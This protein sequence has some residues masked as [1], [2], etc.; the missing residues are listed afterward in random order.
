MPLLL[1]YTSFAKESATSSLCQRV[2]A[3]DHVVAV[4]MSI[5]KYKVPAQQAQPS[6]LLYSI[7]PASA[8]PNA[9]IIQ[10]KSQNSTEQTINLLNLKVQDG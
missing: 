9:D 1:D 8:D 4:N 3:S 7:N 10:I 5:D 6:M 2:T